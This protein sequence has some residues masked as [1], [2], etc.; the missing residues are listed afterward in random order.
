VRDGR[1]GDDLDRLERGIADVLEQ[2]LAGAEQH[3]D[4][5]EVE[6][7]EEPA[8]R[9][10]CTALAPPAIATSRSPAGARACS[11][12]DSIPSVTNVNVVPPCMA[13]GSR[14]WWVRT[15]TGAW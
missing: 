1:R 7:V 12:A 8:R 13:S 5:V 11:R 3:R 6:L 9:Y 2:P 4:E 14:S 10:C 15:K